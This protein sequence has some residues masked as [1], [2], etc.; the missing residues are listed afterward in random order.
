MPVDLST[1]QTFPRELGRSTSASPQN[2]YR[3][4]VD[5]VRCSRRLFSSQ[6]ELPEG[7]PARGSSL[8]APRRWLRHG[9]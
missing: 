1:I 8:A 6:Y 9:S 2:V 5:I 3:T 7:E 4:V